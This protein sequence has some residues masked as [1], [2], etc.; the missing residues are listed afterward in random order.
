MHLTG[1]PV[2]IGKAS[3]EWC[4]PLSAIIALP[5]GRFSEATGDELVMA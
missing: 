1:R 4:G 5:L 2:E 3:V